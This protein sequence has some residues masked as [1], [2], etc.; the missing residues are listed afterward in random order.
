MAGRHKWARVAVAAG[1]A[2]AGAV[3]FDPMA[4]AALALYS[5]PAPPITV[6]SSVIG[7]LDGATAIERAR[8][9]GNVIPGGPSAV[10][11]SVWG[12]AAKGGTAVMVGVT[13]FFIGFEGASAVLGWAGVDDVGLKALFPTAVDP[14]FIPNADVVLVEPGWVG[15]DSTFNSCWVAS[16]VCG[17]A[18]AVRVTIV[19]SPAYG[20]AGT[21]VVRVIPLS[22][23]PSGYNKVLLN[24]DAGS[25]MMAISSGYYEASIPRYGGDVWPLKFS[26]TAAHITAGT[27]TV[28]WYPVGHP[29][30]PA[31]VISDPTRAWETR[32]TCSD[33]QS[34][35]AQSVQ[36]HETDATLPAVPAASCSMGSPLSVEVWEISP[37]GGPDE[38]L[39]ESWTPTQALLDWQTDYPQCV[40]GSCRLLLSRIDPTTAGRLSCFANPAL[41]VDWWTSPTRADEFE[42]TYGGAV[43]AVTECA[44]YAPT[45][46]VATGVDVQTETGPKPAGEIGPYADPATGEPVPAD[47]PS[48]APAPEPGVGDEDC[49]PPFSWTSMFNPWWYYKGFTC[50]LSWAFVPPAGQI[51]AE[52]DATGDVLSARPPWS[53]VEP[54]G[55]VFTGLGDGWS[56]GCSELPD[57]DPYGNGLRLPCTP[58]QSGWMTVLRALGTFAIIV[59]TGFG[60]WHMVVAAIGGRQA[61]S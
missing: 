14:G 39:I 57:F 59:G 16:W 40:D 31:D 56:T 32:W 24:G 58:P 3:L 60:V 41:C 55:A 53:L 36:F 50:G 20:V 30:R 49:P 23:A 2:G 13:G 15:G 22:S 47:D 33:A 8:M 51:Q 26:D 29:Q 4:P 61:D 37:L 34:Y 12:T 7:S 17:T 1:L 9:V 6:P 11:A 48:P 18:T 38:V 46:N 54:I 27:N 35:S 10:P 44:V 28:R 25:G 5:P 42:C 43:V 52:V 45:F 21:V 19:S